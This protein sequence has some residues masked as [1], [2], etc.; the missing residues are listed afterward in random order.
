MDLSIIGASI[1]KLDGFYT[2]THLS[3]RVDHSRYPAI[4][5]TNDSTAPDNST[6]K[7]PTVNLFLDVLE[8]DYGWGASIVTACVDQTVYAIQCTQGPKTVGSKVCGP[9]AQ[10]HTRSPILNSKNFC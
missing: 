4:R 10:V 1:P 7:P 3:P 2:P 8:G 6:V 5:A 9:S